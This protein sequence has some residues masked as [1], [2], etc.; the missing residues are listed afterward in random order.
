ME[1]ERVAISESCFA[2]P[3]PCVG[4][5]LWMFQSLVSVFRYGSCRA[6]ARADLHRRNLLGS[7]RQ[8]TG[9]AWVSK[10]QSF[11][12]DTDFS[13]DGCAGL[14]ALCTSKERQNFASF[15]RQGRLSAT[16]LS[17][18]K[19]SQRRKP[20]KGLNLRLENPFEIFRPNVVLRVFGV[21]RNFFLST[22]LLFLNS[23]QVTGP[24]GPG[25][26][27]ASARESSG[28]RGPKEVKPKRV[29]APV[30]GKP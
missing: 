17:T 10:R 19:V 28:K 25:N 29:T 20:S 26:K 12:S 5:P 27:R 22:L 4:L 7:A 21:P 13:S 9:A 2:V 18:A 15:F 24:Y 3:E 1:P 16:S 8:T 14:K 23:E 30:D 11:Q 6:R